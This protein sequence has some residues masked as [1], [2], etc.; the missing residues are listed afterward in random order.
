MISFLFV[1]IVMAFGLF[2]NYFFTKT[3]EPHLDEKRIIVTFR[4]KDYDIT[5]FLD[6]HPGGRNV[7]IKKNGRDI[8]KAMQDNN[9]SDDAYAILEKY[10]IN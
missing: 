7:L 9:H 4:N 3:E 8:E 2:Y 1:F 6:E 10:C 5:D